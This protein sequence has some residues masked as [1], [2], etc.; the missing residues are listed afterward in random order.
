MKIALRT[1]LTVLIAVGFAPWSA[2][3]MGMGRPPSIAGVFNP[4]V[5]SGASYEMTRKS[6]EDFPLQHERLRGAG[7]FCAVSYRKSP[8]RCMTPDIRHAA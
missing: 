1:V 4:L 3:Q 8:A 6:V 5:G 7:L 2:G